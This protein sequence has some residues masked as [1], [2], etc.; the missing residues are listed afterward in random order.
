M[1]K[2]K[3]RTEA[4]ALLGRTLASMNLARPVVFALP[5]GGAPVGVEVSK[6]LGAPFDFIFVRKIG[7]P[8][9]DE[10]AIGAVANGQYPVTVLH[11]PTIRDLGVSDDYIRAKTGA[12][13][14]EIDRRRA[15]Y[16]GKLAEQS[17]TGR[18]AVI[19]DDGLATGATMEAA[20]QSMRKAGAACVVVAIPVAPAEILGRFRALADSV[21]CLK[22]PSPF[23]SV[24]YYY[25]DFRQLTDEDVLRLL[26]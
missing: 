18:T 19:V 11:A 14:K 3:D 8:S 9:F 13:L 6:A 12:A 15:A 7:A 2:F 25:D 16:R 1:E 5:R 22:T 21:V 26:R 20:I 17:A 24:G 10:V 23:H 4:G